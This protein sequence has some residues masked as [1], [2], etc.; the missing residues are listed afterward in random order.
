M[1]TSLT[2]RLAASRDFL[3]KLWVLT[4]PYWFAETRQDVTLLGRSFSIR[5]AWIARALLVLVIALSIAIVWTLKLFNDW[6][7]RFFNALNERNEQ[8]FWTEHKY[9]FVLATIYTV[10]AVYRQW[11]RQLLVSVWSFWIKS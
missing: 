3:A 7:G 4:R 9:W 10:I 1:L 6:N 11:L 2:L 5:E 8:A